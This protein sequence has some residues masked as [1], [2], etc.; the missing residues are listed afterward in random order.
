MKKLLLTLS[1]SLLLLASP[2]WA[3]NWP[4]IT[5]MQS[6]GDY[7][8]IVFFW[9]A[10]ST[11]FS[12]DD[13]SGGDNT[14]TAIGSG[15]EINS[16]AGYIGT[17]GVYVPTSGGRVYSFDV[18]GNDIVPTSGRLGF[19]YYSNDL[20]STTTPIY[21]SIADASTRMQF[22]ISGNDI[23]FYWR[24]SGAGRTACTSNT[25]VVAGS[26]WQFIELAWDV[27]YREAFVDGESVLECTTT[28][29]SQSPTRFFI[30]D[31]DS[32]SDAEP[33]HLDNIMVSNDKT[34][35]LYALRNFTSSPR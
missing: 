22:Q 14:P 9:T 26:T 34:R 11:T 28:T 16:D 27:N 10:E 17:N 21:W 5:A 23:S 6:G 15:L 2:C 35:D 12:A 30:G 13:Y 18:D 32:T 33:K 8:D 25:D 1:L 24:D 20:S 7:S 3:W 4:V 19:W 29:S 31:E